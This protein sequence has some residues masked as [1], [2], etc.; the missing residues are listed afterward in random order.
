MGPERRRQILIAVAAGALLTRIATAQQQSKIWRI[1]F[2]L[3]RA[4]DAT[5]EADIIGP[6]LRGMRE[7]GYIEGKNVTYE[8]RAADSQYGRLPQLAAELV[9]LRVDLIVAST[10][11]SARAA[12]RATKTIPIVMVSVSD[13][14]GTGL[15]ASLSHPGAN[16]TGVSNYQGDTSQKQI[17]YLIEV[18]GKPSRIAAMLNPDNPATEPAFRSVLGATQ[19]NGVQLI[20]LQVRTVT[21]IDRAFVTAKRDRAQGLIAIA[22]TF[23]SQQRAQIVRLAN[24]AR[25]PAMFYLKEFAEMGGL[26]SYGPSTVDINRRGAT[27][28]DKIIRGAKPADLPVEQPTRVELVVNLKTANALGVTIPQSILLRAD[29]VIE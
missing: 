15:V 18:L 26:M 28:V 24:E 1:G 11:P 4:R 17:D 21:D 6:F 3:A 12:Q 7:L 10:T 13:P 20:S 25:L 19:R 22:D 2:L 27:Y 16:I 14:I 8:F 29:R 5:S 9:K 23:L